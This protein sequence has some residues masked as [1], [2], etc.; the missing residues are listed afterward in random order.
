MSQ[1]EWKERQLTSRGFVWTADCSGNFAVFSLDCI[2]HLACPSIF[3]PLKH[4]GCLCTCV[5]WHHLILALTGGRPVMAS[6]GIQL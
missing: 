4:C 3:H 1:K 6:S 5:R 2:C